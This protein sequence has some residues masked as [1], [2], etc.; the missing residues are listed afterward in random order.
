MI[1]TGKGW[2][3]DELLDDQADLW[4]LVPMDQL[5]TM[6]G[7]VRLLF[8]LTMGTVTRQDGKRQAK[9]PILAVL[10]EFTRLGKMDKILDIATVAAG[11]GVE[12]LFVAQDR[13]ALDEVYGETGASTIIGACAT[14]RVF[15]LGRGDARTAE[16]LERIM[17][18]MTVKTTSQRGQETSRS[19]AKDK[20][21]AAADSLEMPQGQALCLIR[22]HAPV[23]VWLCRSYRDVAFRKR[24]DP[25][26]TVR[27]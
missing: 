18:A 8:S 10:D 9:Q 23:K 25:N 20:L 17:R 7:F 24:C 21:M 16:W 13:A 19:E 26:P 3:I 15:G 2:S 6:R 4:I 22:D 12:A 27:L 11:S 5:G 14:I 1:K